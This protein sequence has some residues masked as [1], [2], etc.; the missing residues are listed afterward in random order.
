MV[1]TVWGDTPATALAEGYREGVDMQNYGSQQ[2]SKTSLLADQ[3]AQAKQ[4]AQNRL[5]ALAVDKQTK[6]E[7]GEKFKGDL[8]SQAQMYKLAMTH[9]SNPAVLEDYRSKLKDITAEIRGQALANLYA[10]RDEQSK[11]FDVFSQA[12]ASGDLSSLKNSNDP[13][14]IQMGRIFSDEAPL[15]DPA[16]K[17]RMWSSLSGPEQQ[18]ILGRVETKLAPE[19]SLNTLQTLYKNQMNE[20]KVKAD[21]EAKAKA[22]AEKRQEEMEKRSQDKAKLAETTRH[23]K[24]MEAIQSARESLRVSMGSAKI[25]ADKTK[26]MVDADQKYTKLISEAQKRVAAAKV[27]TEK[28]FK[29]AG[30][31]EELSNAEDELRTLENNYSDAKEMFGKHDV[32]VKDVKKNKSNESDDLKAS[33]ESH[34]WKYEP[35]KY[36]YRVGPNGVPQRKLKG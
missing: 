8:E 29:P 13:T 6:A 10:R 32:A 1:A 28:W 19:N 5:E 22:L 12:Q 23:N 20:D 3:A 11:R 15:Q 35:D 18:M 36:E 21:S 17:G 25:E 30:A 33:V 27:K 16:F 9:T 4:A 14:L 2:E 34:G 7:M 31:D 26:A 24:A